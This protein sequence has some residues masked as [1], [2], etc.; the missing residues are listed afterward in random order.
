MADMSVAIELGGGNLGDQ[1]SQFSE[2]MRSVTQ[3]FGG[4]GGRSKVGGSFADSPEGMREMNRQLDQMRQMAKQG[5]MAVGPAQITK[6][7][8]GYDVSADVRA[9]QPNEKLVAGISDLREGMTNLVPGG[10]IINSFEKSGLFAGIA[11]GV[12]AIS[13]AIKNVVQGSQVYQT[14]IGTVMKTVSAIVDVFLAPFMP[15]FAKIAVWLIQNIMPKAAAWGDALTSLPGGGA[16]AVAGLAAAGIVGYL[17]L[18]AATSVIG[19]L[20]SSLGTSVFNALIGGGAGKEIGEG[21]AD[22]LSSGVKGRGIGR[23]LGRAIGGAITI[24]RRILSVLGSGIGGAIKLPS[25]LLSSAGVSMGG[26]LAGHIGKANLL[27]KILP[28]G[29]AVAIA[30]AMGI[31]MWQRYKQVQKDD[32][33]LKGMTQVEQLGHLQ[34]IGVDES[35]AKRYMAI[36][37]DKKLDSSKEMVENFQLFANMQQTMQTFGTGMSGMDKKY[38]DQFET[39]GPQWQK[40]FRD[41]YLPGQGD[42]DPGMLAAVTSELNAIIGTTSKAKQDELHKSGEL[43]RVTSGMTTMTDG[44]HDRTKRGDWLAKQ[45][46]TEQIAKEYGL[47]MADMTLWDVGGVGIGSAEEKRKRALLSVQHSSAEYQAEG[48]SGSL[49]K[50]TDVLGQTTIYIQEGQKLPQD[51]VAWLET[52]IQG[53]NVRMGPELQAQYQSLENSVK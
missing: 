22:A 13:A 20:G 9:R 25:K 28:L 42:M 31:A 11:T 16:T 35:V 7:D 53:D 3:Q 5:N 6:T 10:N 43:L 49:F 32:D 19:N 39:L 15:I 14:M 52:M 12:V 37:E 4:V 45:Y 34:G 30:G 44:S 8:S 2:A 21:A 46:M 51:V 50:S 26:G 1:M 48:F 36:R 29:G 23:T 33:V 27:T 40:F 47:S 17:G 18:K 24:P 38:K 41:E